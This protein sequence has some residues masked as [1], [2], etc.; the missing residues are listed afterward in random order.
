MKM[1]MVVRAPCDGVI[2]KVVAKKEMKVD[3]DD[4]LFIV[5]C[6]RASC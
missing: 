3:N 1:E 2:E 5:A 6:C 4:L